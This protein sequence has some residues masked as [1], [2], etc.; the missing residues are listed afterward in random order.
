MV[1]EAGIKFEGERDE[2]ENERKERN[3]LGGKDAVKFDK[4]ANDKNWK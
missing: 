1:Q 4:I 2:S 3:S